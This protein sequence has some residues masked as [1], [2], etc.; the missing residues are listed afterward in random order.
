MNKKEY[1]EQLEKYL[2]CLPKDDF[3]KTM[4]H[5][6]EYFEEVGEEGEAD[7]IKELGSPKE[8]AYELL[9]Q[10]LET[11]EKPTG[12]KSYKHEKKNKLS[13]GA[14]IGIAIIA[15]LASPLAI[16]LAFTAVALIITLVALVG[17]IILAVILMC[18][19]GFIA[20]IKLLA[21]GVITV[22]ASV[23]GAIALFGAGVLSLGACLV[24]VAL[25]I[26]VVK[27]LG[28]GIGRFANWITGFGGEKRESMD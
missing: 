7:A 23:A 8:V 11:G 19:A 21:T 27:L 26:A 20:G 25:T 14:I 2:R 15:I 22:T 24:V 17:A 18:V 5:F 12:D 28:N 10:L 16:P 1:L 4:E 6:R 9:S 13:T 3:V